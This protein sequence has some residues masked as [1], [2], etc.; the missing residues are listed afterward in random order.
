MASN[1]KLLIET[2]SPNEHIVRLLGRWKDKEGLCRSHPTNLRSNPDLI[3]EYCSGGTWQEFLLDNTM[4]RDQTKQI[5]YQLAKALAHIHQ[6]NIVHGDIKPSNILF[7]DES[8]STVCVVD[9][10]TAVKSLTWPVTRK[11]A[12]T[13]M[14]ASPESMD[15]ELQPA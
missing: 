6:N 12:G 9:F 1:E 10:G 14:Y 11:F 8:H 3:L 13:L 5:L 4:N 7:H 15:S 2:L